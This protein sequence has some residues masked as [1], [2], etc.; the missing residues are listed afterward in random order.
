MSVFQTS[1]IFIFSLGIGRL[2]LQRPQPWHVSLLS[3]HRQ[4][5]WISES[6]LPASLL[7]HHFL[8]IFCFLVT[9]ISDHELVMVTALHMWSNL[10]KMQLI[11]GYFVYI[12][13]VSFASWCNRDHWRQRR[14]AWDICDKNLF[15]DR[16]VSTMPRVSLT[17]TPSSPMGLTSDEFLM[18]HS[19]PRLC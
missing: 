18:T 17:V 16:Y 1:R 14:L 11:Y 7:M 5:D 6:S 4:S 15:M 19:T 8:L 9:C 2:P 13:E 12:A 3:A 10:S